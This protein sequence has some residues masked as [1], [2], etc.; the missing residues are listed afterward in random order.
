[1]SNQTGRPTVMTDETV[2]KLE[3]AL[4]DGFSVERACYLSGVGRST[5]YDHSNGNPD[6]ADKMYLAQEWATER[7]KQVTIQAID[8]GNV[9]AAQWWLERKA[10]QEFGA[11]LAVQPQPESD[12]FTK[13]TPDEVYDLM[14]R[15]IK[16]L[17]ETDF[18]V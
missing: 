10:H 8:G 15:S 2:Q 7:A 6:F 5:F 11:K 14:E 1:M 16:A 12:I 13:R 18:V 4:Q 3:Q 9:K 17:S